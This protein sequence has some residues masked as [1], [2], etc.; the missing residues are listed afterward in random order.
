VHCWPNWKCKHHARRLSAPTVSTRPRRLLSGV[1]L[2]RAFPRA[3]VPRLLTPFTLRSIIPNM[4]S[5][6]DD[7]RLSIVMGLRQGL[8]PVRGMRRACSQFDFSKRTPQWPHRES[9]SK[10]I[11]FWKSGKK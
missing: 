5:K 4:W 2:A 11:F 8:R 6:A 10:R 3:V 1:Y 9:I 7:L